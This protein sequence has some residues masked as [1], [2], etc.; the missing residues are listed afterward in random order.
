MHSRKKCQHSLDAA[1]QG[2]QV[3]GG[4]VGQQRRLDVPLGLKQL[5]FR[6]SGEGGWLMFASI[7]R[8]GRVRGLCAVLSPAPPAT[9]R[10]LALDSE[11]PGPG[12][13]A[14]ESLFSQS[15]P[16]FTSPQS[17]LQPHKRLCAAVQCLHVAGI[18][19]KHLQTMAALQRVKSD[20]WEGHTWCV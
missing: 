5:L 2:Q 9:P 16:C 8:V 17:H 13:H 14:Y 12:P 20:V 7:R 4:G 11:P 19:L 1:L 6:V 18:T 10:A 3:G 15:I